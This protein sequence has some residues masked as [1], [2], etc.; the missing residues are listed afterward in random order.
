M[1]KLTIIFSIAV[2]LF[3][4]NGVMAQ[5]DVQERNAQEEV[6]LD[7]NVQPEDLGVKEPTLLPDSPFYF[8]K[9]W[10]RGIRSFFTF[11]PIAKAELK[12]RFASEKLM[13]LK[14]MQEKGKGT[15]AIQKAAESYREELERVKKAVEKI[16]E[17]A[18]ENKRVNSFLDKFIK[19][20]LLHQRLLQKLETQVPPEAFQKIKEARERHIEKFGEVMTRLEENKEK[21]RERL[22]KN[23]QEVKGSEFKNFKNLEILK[24]LE[25]KVP[26][27]AKEA[28]QKARENILKRLELKIEEMPQQQLE[29]FRSYT[30]KIAG[31]KEKQMEILESLKARLEDKPLLQ[32]KILQSREAVLEKIRTRV[33][34]A[35]CPEIDKPAPDFCKEGRLIIEKDEKGCIINFRCVIPEKVE[36]TLPLKPGGEEKKVCITLWDPVCG[37]DGKTYSNECYAELA[38][39]E[40]AYRGVCTQERIW[41]KLKPE[42]TP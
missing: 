18:E 38:G 33:R 7:E 35:D 29:K 34:A 21:I 24:Y 41:Q 27:E 28:I 22:E 42:L 15:Q 2:L 11:N 3:A 30:E 39:V 20:Q 26:E 40:I 10:G 36:P 4:F 12:E 1:K 32:Q 16:K 19:H 25:E 17:K 8:L 23:L 13:E 6:S 5:E 9:D 37:K 14:K 31:E